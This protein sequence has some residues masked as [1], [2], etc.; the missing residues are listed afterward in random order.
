MYS[1]ISSPLKRGLSK[2][3]SMYYLLNQ[4]IQLARKTWF[5]VL[6]TVKL[7][8]SKKKKSKLFFVKIRR[9]LLDLNW[10]RTQKITK[11]SCCCLRRAS[12]KLDDNLG[13]IKWSFADFVKRWVDNHQVKYS[14]IIRQFNEHFQVYFQIKPKHWSQVWIRI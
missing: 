1:I 3:N 2:T 5:L 7:K 9:F 8:D 12:W 4:I 11:I 13:R 6:A 10:I 14:Y